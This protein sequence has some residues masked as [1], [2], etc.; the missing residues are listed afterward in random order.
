MGD[1]GAAGD[2]RVHRK[3]E[4][5]MSRNLWL[6]GLGTKRG[7]TW[8]ERPPRMRKARG[9][10][11]SVT[12]A[13]KADAAFHSIYTER[14]AARR[15]RARV[16][17]VKSSSSPPLPTLTTLSSPAPTHAVKSITPT[18]LPRSYEREGAS[19]TAHACRAGAKRGRRGTRRRNNT[20]TGAPEARREAQEAAGA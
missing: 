9:R 19:V 14:G 8:E 3:Q 16:P 18:A 10:R 4:E 17:R 13:Q 6:R 7:R 11:A 2:G 1:P 15:P 5:D 12:R 20:R